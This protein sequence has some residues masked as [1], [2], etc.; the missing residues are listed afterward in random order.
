MSADDAVMR[1]VRAG[2]LVTLQ[3]AGRFGRLRFGISASG[4]M[5]RFSH[6]AANV[7]IGNDRDTT[8]IEVSAA[9]VEL[10]CGQRSTTVSV[11]GGAARIE[12]DGDQVVGATVLTMH[13]SQR[14]VVRSGEWGS[15]AYI[16]VAGDIGVDPWLGSAS[17]HSIAG[18]GGAVLHGGRKLIV[19]E[20]RAEA[21]REGSFGDLMPKRSL[22][23]I[24]VVLG[25]Q[26]HHFLDQ[27]VEALRTNP[28]AL[29]E[30][31]DRMGVR[32]N[33]PKLPLRDVL[34][35][36]SE[37]IV[38]G[39]IQVSGDGAATVLL[40]DHQTTGGYP[41]IATIISA[42]LD[43]FVQNRP[44]DHVRFEVIEPETAVSLVRDQNQ[45][46][47]SVLQSIGQPGR[48]LAARLMSEDL[49]GSHATSSI[50]AERRGEADV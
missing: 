39:S 26:Q 30:A 9:G 35:I 45:R 46:L 4:P 29:T 3:D 19:S 41:K 28:F 8:A 22:E 42:D 7:A 38:R 44:G 10:E 12:H 17:T 36:P 23:P 27:A 13:P 43:R 37:P 34:S 47:E 20:P 1:V 32:L 18:L 11:T 49:I 2:P 48:N 31:Y 50:D 6:A 21:E 15:W 14:L 5:D 16:A 24:R 33:G 40:A 25:P